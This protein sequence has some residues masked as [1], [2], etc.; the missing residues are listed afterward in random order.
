MRALRF[1]G[2]LETLVGDL[3]AQGAL[4]AQQVLGPRE[5]W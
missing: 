3:E 5:G 2:A 4:V 1:L